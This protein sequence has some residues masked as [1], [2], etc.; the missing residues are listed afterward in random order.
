[1]PEL[2]QEPELE[3]EP[4][5]ALVG[6][7]RADSLDVQQSAGESFAEGANRLGDLSEWRAGVA[8]NRSPTA[9]VC[10]PARA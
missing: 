3:L 10:S 4:E 6:K 5:S 2:E 8:E 7:R 1:L 9:A